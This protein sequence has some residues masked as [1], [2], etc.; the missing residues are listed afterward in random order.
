MKPSTQGQDGVNTRQQ[1]SSEETRVGST[2]DSSKCLLAGDIAIACIGVP[3]ANATKEQ[4][5]ILLQLSHG[6]RETCNWNIPNNDQ[7]G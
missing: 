1:L 7:V 2:S 5:I 4:M 3:L 6:S